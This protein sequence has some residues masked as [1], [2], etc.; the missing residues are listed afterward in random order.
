M[1]LFDAEYLKNGTRYI[2]RERKKEPFTDL[3]ENFNIAE[4][5]LNLYMWK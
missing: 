4:G 5:M 3:N 1:P 2:H